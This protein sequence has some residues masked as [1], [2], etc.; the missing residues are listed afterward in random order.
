MSAHTHKQTQLFYGK[1]EG[2]E[3]IK[4]I[5]EFNAGTTSGDW[6][7]GTADELGVPKSVMR[8]GTERGYSCVSFND[9]QYEITYKV[10]G[11]PEDYQINLWVPKVIPF[12]TKNAARIVANFFM[13]SKQDK[14]EYRI[15]N[16]EWK[17]MDYTESIDPDY[18]NNVLKW[19][20]TQELFTGRRPSNPEASK[21]IWTA[22]FSRKLELGTHEVEVRAKDRYGKT[23]TTKST[24]EVKNSTLICKS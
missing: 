12:K 1:K 14:V 18:T 19:D 24:F 4:P 17:E 5:H 2:W 3:G 11:K 15:D 9:N 7:S 10:A 8:D 22:P 20:T 13:G 23:Y 16:G 21:H 6:Y